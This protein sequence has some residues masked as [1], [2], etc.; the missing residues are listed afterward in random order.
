MDFS[1]P[2]LRKIKWYPDEYIRYIGIWATST[3]YISFT[4]KNACNFK[5][6]TN[7]RIPGLKG[8]EMML[9]K[10]PSQ[11]C[12][13]LKQLHSLGLM[14]I[15]IWRPLLVFRIMSIFVYTSLVDLGLIYSHIYAYNHTN[16]QYVGMGTYTY[17][18]PYPYISIIGFAI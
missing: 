11:C 2:R 14:Q 8:P 15:Y 13:G 6:A 7:Y 16:H 10:F 4:E 17:A 1:W 3:Y 5:W 12:L 9:C 18:Y